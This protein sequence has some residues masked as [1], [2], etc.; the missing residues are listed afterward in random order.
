MKTEIRPESRTLSG[1]NIDL[2]SQEVG[3]FLA[4]ADVDRREALRIQLILEEILL[5]YREAFS[6][7]AVFRIRCSRRLPAI[8]IEVLIPGEAFDPL[9]KESDE[10]QVIRGLLAGMGLA[11]TWSY[12]NGRNAIV[13][14]L[15]KKPLSGT[16][17]KL[18]AMALA[19][20]AGTVLNLLPEQV[21]AGVNAYLISPMTDVFLGLISA[22]AGPLVF[23]SI[24][25]SICAMGNMET[26]GKIGSKTIQIILLYMT[27]ISLLM[28]GIGVVFYPLARG[29]GGAAGFSQVLELIYNIFPSNLF[30]PF[31]TGN[32][33]QLI[34]IAVIVGLSM[35][36]LS[37]RVSGVFSLVE[38]L[39]AIVQTVMSGLSALLP[40]LIFLLFT[41][42][43]ISG[44]LAVLVSSWKMVAVIL[45]LMAAYLALNLLW[46]SVR[47]KVSPALLLAKIWPT[48]MICLTTASSAAAFSTNTR[49]S[50]REL[51]IHKKLVEFGTPLGQVL[52][53]PGFVALLFGMEIGFA[54]AYGIP[55]TLPWLVTGLITNLLV[56]FATP[57]IPGG[58]MMGLTV[59]FTQMGIPLEVMGV[60][61][62]VIAV[63][64]FFSTA[65]NVSGWQLTMIEAAD[66]L[67]MLDREV[68]LAKPSRQDPKH[69]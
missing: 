5:K 55:I 28:M 56:S 38:Q 31:V 14:L 16:V 51:G 44:N 2:T 61:F 58:S 52:F 29:G 49:D 34:F 62:A 36:M 20:A 45:L 41:G 21:S 11:P 42:M 26:L 59:A 10:D 60:A 6:E 69:R 46:I 19:V 57:P 48:M 67:G 8:R 17:K 37:S 25:G 13:F 12:K 43:I 66:S 30:E 40:V 3:R 15:R 32:I 68:L 1:S 47:K 33:L 24:L 53:R 18:L 4:G 27:V 22:V 35:L 63:A 9:H 54:Q 7:E 64:D 50:H 23:L 39:T 65:T